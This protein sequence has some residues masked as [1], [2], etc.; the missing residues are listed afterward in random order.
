M[1]RIPLIELDDA[2]D[3]VKAIYRDFQELG[4]PLFN[5][6]KLFGND[7]GFLDG[8]G[9]MIKSLYGEDSPLDPRYRELAWLRASQLNACHY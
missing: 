4:F 1:S 3:N 2:D 8:L 7:S 9:R 5:V 6:I